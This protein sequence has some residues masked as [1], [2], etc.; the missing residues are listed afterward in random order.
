M[1]SKGRGS[2]A[3]TSGIREWNLDFNHCVNYQAGGRLYPCLW[4]ADDAGSIRLI[5]FVALQRSEAA[6]LARAARDGLEVT[7][8]TWTKILTRN[9]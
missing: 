5:W 6:K 8:W 3:L 9:A 2:T 7:G 1:D 4:S